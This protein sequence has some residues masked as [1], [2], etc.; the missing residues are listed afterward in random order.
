MIA[1][2]TSAAAVGRKLTMSEAWAATR[3]KRLAA[4]RD[5]AP[6]RV[7]VLAALAVVAG[8]LLI[9]IFAFDAPLPPPWSS[10]SCWG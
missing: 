8:V 9:G 1:H 3:G 7:G 10:A 2:V 4:V 6:A 5:G